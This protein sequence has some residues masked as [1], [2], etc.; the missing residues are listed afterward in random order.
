MKIGTSER[1][2][3]PA[4]GEPLIDARDFCTG[5]GLPTGGMAVDGLCMGC[6]DW[7]RPNIPRTDLRSQVDGPFR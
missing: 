6:H 4:R 2:K 7:S 5:C 1:G 3:V